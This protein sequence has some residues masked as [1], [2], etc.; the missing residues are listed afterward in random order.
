MHIPA[1][2][3][4]NYAALRDGQVQCWGYNFRGQLGNGGTTKRYTSAGGH[5][6]KRHR[7]RGRRGDHSC[8]LPSG[9]RHQV[10]GLQRRRQAGAASGSDLTNPVD[11]AQRHHRP[12]ISAEHLHL[13]LLAS[14]TVKYWGP[15][16]LTA[17]LAT[18][19]TF[20]RGGRRM[21]MQSLTSVSQ[22]PLAGCT[23]AALVSGGV[24]C[25][26]SN[27]ACWAPATPRRNAWVNAYPTLM[28]N[29]TDHTRPVNSTVAQFAGPPGIECWGYSGNGRLGCDTIVGTGITVGTA[30]VLGSDNFVP[31]SAPDV[32]HL[33]PHR[34]QQCQSAEGQWCRQLLHHFATGGDD[35]ADC[36]SLSRRVANLI[37][38]AVASSAATDGVLAARAWLA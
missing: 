38:T 24:V 18:A 16:T 34:G 27:T 20:R 21:T 6:D 5:G 11:V 14:N 36:H 17:S 35:H 3:S 32:P 10:L 9:R 37:S 28:T 25:W 29:V 26:G 8:A 33:R 31:V 2:T 15:A 12:A 7:F 30:K 22:S 23:C 1:G 19:A 13:R 4:H